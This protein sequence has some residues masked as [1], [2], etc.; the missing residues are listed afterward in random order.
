MNF[1]PPDEVTVKL[2]E[3]EGMLHAAEAELVFLREAYWRFTI[4]AQNRHR[5]DHHIRLGID[6]HT[7]GIA[8]DADGNPILVP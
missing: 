8:F 7:H 3:T 6:L 2:F 5:L 4:A 1:P